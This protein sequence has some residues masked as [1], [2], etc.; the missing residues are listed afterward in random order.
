MHH[1]VLCC[2]QTIRPGGNTTTYTTNIYEQDVL[3]NGKSV[4]NQLDTYCKLNATM[5]I[6]SS[7]DTSQDEV[8]QVVLDIG[9]D[10]PVELA[11][12]ATRLDSEALA[13]HP[14][15]T[16]PLTVTGKLAASA[17]PD[18]SLKLYGNLQG[19]EASSSG[20]IGIYE[21]YKCEDAGPLYFGP[22]GTSNPWTTPYSSD[23][24]GNAVVN[25]DVDNIAAEH[26]GGASSRRALV[27]R[28]L[29]RMLQPRHG[30]ARCATSPPYPCGRHLN[31]RASPVVNADRL[32]PASSSS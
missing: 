1:S 21:S 4:M 23:G 11:A 9:K 6:L 30:I 26:R 31:P 18:K 28:R 25:V 5:N 10:L 20:I 14:S 17:Y 15:Y 3:Y 2:A 27:H 19:L 29:P 13:T 32:R 16:G 22:N 7:I 24:S 8:Q 12:F